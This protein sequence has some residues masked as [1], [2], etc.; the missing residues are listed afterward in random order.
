MVKQHLTMMC[1]NWGE[2]HNWLQK[3][4]TRT[5]FLLRILAGRSQAV[6]FPKEVIGRELVGL[7]SGRFERSKGFYKVYSREDVTWWNMEVKLC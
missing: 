2:T 4:Q 3:K 5:V 7:R 6:L 1:F